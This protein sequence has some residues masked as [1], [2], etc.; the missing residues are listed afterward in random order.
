ME[1]FW[2]YLWSWNSL[3]DTLATS[4]Q[5]NPDITAYSHF[6]SKACV[7]CGLIHFSNWWVPRG[8]IPR[9]YSANIMPKAHNITVRFKVVMK[10]DPPGWKNNKIQQRKFRIHTTDAMDG[11]T[12]D[13]YINAMEQNAYKMYV[14]NCCKIKVLLLSQADVSLVWQLREGTECIFVIACCVRHLFPWTDMSGQLYLKT[15]HIFFLKCKCSS[16]S[17]PM[18]QFSML[19]ISC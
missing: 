17:V 9:T 2:N 10:T 18:R 13:H 8:I 3:A 16:Y 15:I 14:L 11:N 12:S 19:T 7:S 1:L 5:H 4:Q 6:S